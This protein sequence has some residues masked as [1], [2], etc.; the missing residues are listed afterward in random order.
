M[1]NQG[2]DGPW[3]P[4]S[5]EPWYIYINTKAVLEYCEAVWS[6]DGSKGGS[7][8]RLKR[9]PSILMRLLSAERVL[10]G[11]VLNSHVTGKTP[12]TNRHSYL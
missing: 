3:A 7:A 4:V 9:A 12:F 10:Y 8:T 11:T 6:G 5:F 1:E 2:A